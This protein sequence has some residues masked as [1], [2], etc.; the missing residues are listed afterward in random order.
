MPS[1]SPHRLR[2]FHVSGT[3][4]RSGV[5]VSVGAVCAC[6]QMWG[7]EAGVVVDALPCLSPC[8][9]GSQPTLGWEFLHKHKVVS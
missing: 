5:Q 1:T 3:V 8:W 6:V 4:V 9:P 7:A 2:G